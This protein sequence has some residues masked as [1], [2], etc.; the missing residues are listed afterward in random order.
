MLKISSNIPPD[1]FGKQIES[2][3]QK[4]LDDSYIEFDCPNCKKQIKVKYI[5]VRKSRRVICHHCDQGIKL[6]YTEK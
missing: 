6:Q 3:L 2:F 4:A 1:Q 5:D